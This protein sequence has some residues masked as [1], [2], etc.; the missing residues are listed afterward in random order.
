MM[1]ISGRPKHNDES[2]NVANNATKKLFIEGTIKLLL[3]N[4][5]GEL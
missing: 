5:V 3:K 1:V 2:I 4:L